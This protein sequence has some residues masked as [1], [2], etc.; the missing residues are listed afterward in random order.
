MDE[1]I[2][3]KAGLFTSVQDGGRFGFEAFGIP[4]S[5]S[6]DKRSAAL[7]NL[8]VGNKANEA[9]FEITLLGP[10]IEFNCSVQFCISGAELSP[11]LNNS[12]IENNKVYHAYE[13]DVLSFGQA[14]KGCRAYLAIGG[15]ISVTEI[16]SSK[17][18]YT[19][20]KIGGF[21]GRVLE[22]GDVIPI[23]PII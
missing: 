17:S 22:K 11:R 16:M 13:K 2:F 23:K 8:L 6:M 15:Y 4:V 1:L 21:K 7:S 14:L 10:T 20:G 18:T 12:F 3:H 19:Y 5:G 9:V